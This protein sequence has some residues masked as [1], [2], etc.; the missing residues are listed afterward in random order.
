MEQRARRKKNTRAI[1]KLGELLR[2]VMESYVWEE[3]VPAATLAGTIDSAGT[4]GVEAR[5]EGQNAVERHDEKEHEEQ[6][7][8]YEE[9]GEPEYYFDPAD[10]QGAVDEAISSFIKEKL[11]KRF[12]D[13]KTPPTLGDVFSELFGENSELKEKAEYFEELISG[14]ED[15]AHVDDLREAYEVLRSIVN[16][17]SPED[18]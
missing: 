5:D 4:H 15:R 7:E 8:E 6:P 12:D 9:Y 2:D 14:Y 17:I 3:V 13:P 10:I 11:V 16:D 1:R 18:N